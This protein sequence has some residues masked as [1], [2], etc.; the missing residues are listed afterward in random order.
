MDANALINGTQKT[1]G[2]FSASSTHPSQGSAQ[3]FE[4]LLQH[5]QG[6]DQFVSS[7]DSN[8]SR[9][10]QPV[11]DIYADEVAPAESSNRPAVIPP[12]VMS[13]GQ[14]MSDE[15]KAGKSK[16]S[17]LFDESM[18]SEIPIIAAYQA[19]LG[20]VVKMQDSMTNFSISMKAVELSSTAF[21][22]LYKM[23]G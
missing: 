18:R 23:Q 20:E 7:N 8:T 14:A 3:R 2:E 13:Y 4:S 5:A 17:A 21:S 19:H 6:T 15:L 1:L 11:G 22:T 10:L 9:L 16:K 12:E